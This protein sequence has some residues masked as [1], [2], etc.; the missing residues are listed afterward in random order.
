MHR[1]V[2]LEIDGVSSKQA[3]EIDCH[4]FVHSEGNRGRSSSKGSADAGGFSSQMNSHKKLIN[5]DSKYKINRA[6]NLMESVKLGLVCARQGL[7]AYVIQDTPRFASVC[8]I[9]SVMDPPV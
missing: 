6:L 4:V 8:S 5:R 9:A 3:V 7:A 1:P 2:S